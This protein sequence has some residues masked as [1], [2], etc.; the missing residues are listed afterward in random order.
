[1]IRPPFSFPSG[2]NGTVNIFGYFFCYLNRY[3]QYYRTWR[4][5]NVKRHSSCP[6]CFQV[7]FDSDLYYACFI[8]LLALSNGYVT[9]IA[10]MHGPKVMVEKDHQE[11]CWVNSNQVLKACHFIHL[12][13]FM[14]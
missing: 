12:G 11:Q 5:L 10:L 4:G 14:R 8:F 7:I 3:G 1:M 6:S 2:Q 13:I 9:S